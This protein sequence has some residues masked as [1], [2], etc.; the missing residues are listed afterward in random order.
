MCPAATLTRRLRLGL[1]FA[2]RLRA[3]DA[4]GYVIVQVLSAVAAVACWPSS[5]VASR[6]LMWSRVALP[7]M[8]T[9]RIR[10][11]A[12]PSVPRSSRFVMTFF[13]LIVILGTTGK[14]AA[15]VIDSAAK[16]TLVN[17]FSR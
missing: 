6:G 12:I 2:G 15:V 16:L 1:L 4:I 8:A 17:T 5:P 13:F 7:A 14:R 9:A 3:T 11:V 10:R